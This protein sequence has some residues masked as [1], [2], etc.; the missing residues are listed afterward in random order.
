VADFGLAKAVSGG[1]GS[2]GGL[3]RTGVGLG[4]PA[5]MAPE[6]RTDAARVDARADVYA[7]GALLH[8]L[9]R[10]CRLSPSDPLDAPT[11]DPW[12]QLRARLLAADPAERPADAGV[13]LAGL[14]PTEAP[15]DATLRACRALALVPEA[16]SLLREST[17]GASPPHNLPDAA[18]TVS[19][20]VEELTTLA[21]LLQD[22]HRLVTIVGLAGA[23]KTR[24]ALAHAS[25]WLDDHPGGA[26]FCDLTDARSPTDVALALAAALSEP[27]PA[28]DP[29]VAVGGALAARGRC[30]VLL[31]RFEHL[32]AHA[33]ATV[34]VW[35]DRAPQ[36]QLL[37][38][39]RQ[40]LGLRGEVVFELRPTSG[41]AA[42]ARRIWDDLSGEE[43]SAVVQLTS[44]A[45]GFRVEEA[46]A[47]LVLD[48]L[49]PLDALQ[50][51]VHKSVVRE[52]EA[53]VFEVVA[54]VASYAREHGP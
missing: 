47:A 4:T 37:V 24:L 54:W 48:T 19:E 46:A 49:W 17:A 14:P 8:E 52:V 30:L 15:N 44:F 9:L 1:D 26:W 3:T 25:I 21:G 50:G 2:E 51:L 38:T 34:G 53:G 5:Y 6:Q 22:G 33:E 28:E 35:L 27:L 45:R 20:R 40:R 29:V 11:D 12:D 42:D 39:A 16:A 32:A 18:E 23:G 36:A 7:L 43:R 10:G 13:V 31:D 41:G